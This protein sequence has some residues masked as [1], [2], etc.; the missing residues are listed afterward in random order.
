MA[1]FQA[2]MEEVN[3]KLKEADQEVE[4]LTATLKE[5]ESGKDSWEDE[6]AKFEKTAKEQNERIA[7]L[8]EKNAKLLEKVRTLKD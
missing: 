4:K 7:Q 1:K 5:K 3:R 2:K 8:E 6:K